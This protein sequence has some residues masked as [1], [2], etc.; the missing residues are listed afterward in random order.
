MTDKKVRVMVVDD[1][2]FVLEYISMLLDR[3]GYSVS[4]CSNAEDAICKLPAACA[5]VVLTD[6]KMPLISGVELTGK[7]HNLYPDLPVIL[8]TAHADLDVAVDAI[9]KGAFDFITKPCKPD[10][11]LHSIEKAARHSSLLKLEKDYKINLENTVKERS[12][13]LAD[14]LAMLKNL[15]REVIHRLTAAAEF[16]DSHTGAHILRIGLY[17]NKIAEAMEMSAEYTEGITFASMMHDIGKIGIP[18]NILLKPSALTS[19]EFEV[20]KTHTTIGD[21]ILSGSTHPEIRM[22]S[23]I[24]LNHHERWDGTGYPRGL[25]GEDI[26]L[27]GRI[28]IVCD[29]YDALMSKRPYKPS[30][31]HKDVCRIITDGDGRTMPVHFDPMVLQA[32]SEVSPVFEEIFNTLKG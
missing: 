30:L 9:K 3:S 29:Q 21:K 13:E 32:F 4:S 1:D 16:R 22:A 6:V 28:V 10:Y 18:D 31:A 14:A 26:P 15:S 2:P 20:M 5:D 7:I 25:K 23:S 12:R 27:E 19:E 8:M 17:A 11:L 24:A